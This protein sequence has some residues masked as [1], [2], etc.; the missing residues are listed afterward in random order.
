MRD[1]YREM[2]PSGSLEESG[3]LPSS[4]PQITL[5]T[6]MTVSKGV[7]LTIDAK[8]NNTVSRGE[9]E[10]T[11]PC[12]S[13]KSCHPR[14]CRHSGSSRYLSRYQ[15]DLVWD[16]EREDGRTSNFRE[17][18]AI[19]RSDRIDGD[20]LGHCVGTWGRWKVLHCATHHCT[21]NR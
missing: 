20:A 5:P 17:V 11:D 18:F 13:Q 7:P 15:Y 12:S 4:H 14:A 19:A 3:H 21:Q 6:P 16:R 8:I 1:A 10:R 2:K 9:H